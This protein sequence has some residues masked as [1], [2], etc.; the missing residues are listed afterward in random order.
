MVN[1]VQYLH[2]LLALSPTTWA[3]GSVSWPPSRQAIDSTVAPW[4]GSVNTP[5]LQ[6]VFWLTIYSDQVPEAIPF[7]FWCAIPDAS[8]TD[9]RKVSG[10]NG[11]ACFWFNNG[12]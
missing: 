9:P 1:M 2:I 7:M 10:A 11:Q 8:S 3:H 12:W 4:N 6:V 5:S